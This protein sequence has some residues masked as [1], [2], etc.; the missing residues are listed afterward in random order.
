[1]RVIYKVAVAGAVVVT[2]VGVGMGTAFADPSP[3]TLPALTTIVGVDCPPLFVGSPTAN[4]SGSLTNDYNATDPAYPIACWGSDTTGA[5]PGEII[6]KGSSSSDTSCELGRPLTADAGITALNADQ[7][8]STEVNGQPVYCIDFAYADRPPHAG[9]VDA[10]VSLAHDAID[11]SYPEGTSNPQPT[12]LTLAQL[13]DIYECTDTNWDQVGGTNAPIVPVL[14]EPGSGAR[15][16]FLA[17]LGITASSESCWVN[18]VAGNGDRILES[19][20][21]SAG[22]EDQFDPSGTAAVDDIFPYSIGDWIAQGPAVTGTGT[23]GTPGGATVGG[24]ASTIWGHG[25]MALG[26]TVNGT[27]GVAEQPTT[28]NSYSQPV[29]NPNWTPQLDHTLYDVVRNG[30]PSTGACF[31]ATPTYEAVGLPAI[32][33]S[34]GWV[35]TS[36]TAES[37]IV[38]Y[39]FGNLGDNC[40]A[41][42]PGD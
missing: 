20:G 19:T 16:T 2:L 12:S 8:D 17:A 11:W 22:N 28:T 39:G 4:T 13:V 27:L 26:E 14:P 36:D 25:V 35:C 15:D 30:C 32:F 41:L 9:T 31:P 42:A 23:A 21:L 34:K 1:M 37:D 7:E 40:G 38:S 29:I 33:S 6:T 10:F 5:Q 3:S 18:G 24:H